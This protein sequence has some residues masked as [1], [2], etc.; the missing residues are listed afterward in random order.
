MRYRTKATTYT[1]IWIGLGVQNTK[2]EKQTNW[3]LGAY[4]CH[5]FPLHR[6]LDVCFLNNIFSF[7][8]LRILHL[9]Q[10]SSHSLP[11][12]LQFSIFKFDINQCIG[13]YQIW[14]LKIAM[15]QE[16]CETRAEPSVRSWDQKMK[17]YCW[18]NIRPMFY[19]G[20]TYDMNMHPK[21]SL[22][23]FHLLYFVHPV[24]FISKCK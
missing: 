24:L 6:T 21:F 18:E 16:D 7:F 22:F 20:E 5:T 15:L 8:G 11:A 4:S 9:A 1:L 2:G 19:A 13:W 23:A 17:R 14:K 3:T 12:T 10:L